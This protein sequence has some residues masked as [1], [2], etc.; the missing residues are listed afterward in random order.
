MPRLLAE[1][2]RQPIFSRSVRCCGAALSVVLFALEPTRAYAQALP[3]SIARWT[4]VMQVGTLLARDSALT[5]LAV[6]PQETLPAET[7]RVLVAELNRVHQA[8]LSG[9]AYGAPGEAV[10]LIADYY[11]DLVAVVARFGTQEARLALAPAV[12]VSVGISQQVAQLGDTGVAVLMPLLRRRYNEQDVLETLG[13]AW[14]WAD[15]TGSPL[16]DR[17]RAQIVAA[18]T[19]AGFSGLHTDLLGIQGALRA[20]HDPSFLPL[21]QSVHDLAAARGVIGRSTV[22]TME[23]EVI[24]SLTALAASR[25]LASLSSGFARLVAAVCGNAAAGR[26]KGACQSITNDVAAASDHLAKGQTTPARNVFNSVAKKIDSAYA[27]GA[28]SDAE[29]ALLAGNVA[30]LLQRL[31]P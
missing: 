3:D 23:D 31:A 4:R 6:L 27:D 25:S 15:S 21:A 22:V 26:R 20:I 1:I 29:H 28:F 17:S 8:T 16:S 30:M 9:A 14:F 2:A 19:A 5:R 11:M 24:P 10:G 18:L 7:R 13:L 12:A